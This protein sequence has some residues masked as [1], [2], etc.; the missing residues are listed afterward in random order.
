MG[1]KIIH[2]KCLAEMLSQSAYPCR[3]YRCA[4]VFILL[5]FV[6]FSAYGQSAADRKTEKQYN[7]I[8]RKM[9]QNL[10]KNYY[11]DAIQPV[12]HSEYTFNDSSKQLLKAVYIEYLPRPLWFYDDASYER[13]YR[14]NRTRPY[15]H[16]QSAKLFNKYPGT[17]YGATFPV[18]RKS[19]REDINSFHTEL[20]KAI[21]NNRQRRIKAEN[22][23]KK[24]MSNATFSIAYTSDKSIYA[25]GKRTRLY[26]VTDTT[27]NGIPCYKI[28]SKGQ[29]QTI[30]GDKEREK[31]EE[32]L[33][34]GYNKDLTAAEKEALRY[35]VEYWA[36]SEYSRTLDYFVNKKDYALLY[37]R[38]VDRQLN[39][40]TG[41]WK[42]VR[43][44]TEKYEKGAD[45]KYH[46]VYYSEYLINYVHGT[47]FRNDR[48]VATW[49]VQVPLN[50]PYDLPATKKIPQKINLNYEDFCTIVAS[51]D[52]EMLEEWEIF[53]EN[54]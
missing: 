12:R 24:D 9:E 8:I 52:K 11:S 14:L 46:Q 54:M 23:S 38:S 50:K 2:I 3:F 47:V 10:P 18:G 51:P 6:V 32:T 49:I 33:S 25:V 36:D 5:L 19:W 1:N 22:N 53:I 30:Y 26:E 20:Y 37:V 40:A 15:F 13:K 43:Y 41:A 48:D 4:R 35:Y 29:G 39:K 34:T 28:T 17:N 44:F 31:F 27:Y 42:L 21:N 7:R 16:Y 45:A